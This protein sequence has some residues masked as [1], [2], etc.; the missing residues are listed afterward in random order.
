MPRVA[1]HAGPGVLEGLELESRQRETG[2][3]PILE[4]QPSVR[5][6]EMGH[7]SSLPD[8]P[9]EPEASIHRMNHPLAPRCELPIWRCRASRQVA[10]GLAHIF[11]STQFAPVP[12]STTSGTESTAAP[13]ISSRTTT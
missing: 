4:Q 10:T 13:S 12:M 11:V 5:R 1:A 2:A 3:S 6:D 9:M 8:V 7:W